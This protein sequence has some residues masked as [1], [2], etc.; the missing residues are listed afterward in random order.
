MDHAEPNAGTTPARYVCRCEE[1]TE[2][3][4][5]AAI[6]A[7]AR[8][9]N[10]IKRRTRS[11]MGLCQGIFCVGPMAELL[12]RQTGDPLDR[13]LPMTARPPVRLVPLGNLGE[14]EASARHDGDR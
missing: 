3:E 2:A 13:I 12:Q 8:S 6:A 4:I 14:V 1:I 10:D 9:V 5:R 7:G 11:G